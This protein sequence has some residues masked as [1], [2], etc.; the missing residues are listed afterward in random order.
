LAGGAVTALLL[1]AVASLALV[2][3]LQIWPASGTAASFVVLGLRAHIP[4][5]DDLIALVALAGFVGGCLHSLRSV[6]WYVGNR[7]LRWS[8]LPSYFLFPVVGALISVIFYLVLR[9]GF[10]GGPTSTTQVNPYAMAAIGALTGMFSSQAAEKLRSVFET[11]LTKVAPGAD[12]T[13]PAKTLIAGISPTRGPCGSTVI[14]SGSGL[15]GTIAARFGPIA[16]QTPQVVSD[17]EVHIVVPAGAST[18]PI[19]VSTPTGQTDSPLF[20]V[21][22]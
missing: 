8:W 19:T 15:S 21:E 17:S 4:P 13:P 1:A 5:D 12:H 16:A 10:A 9:G 22:T 2:A 20:I 6:A 18:G 11:L 7:T 14:V 3:L